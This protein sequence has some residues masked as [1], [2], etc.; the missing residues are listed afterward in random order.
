MV[1]IVRYIIGLGDQEA[2]ILLK[3]ELQEL[4]N[5]IIVRPKIWDSER[6]VTQEATLSGP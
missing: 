4:G 1:L 6:R 3:T 2:S 5:E